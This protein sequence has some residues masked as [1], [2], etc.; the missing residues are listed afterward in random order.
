MMLLKPAK[1]ERSL[2]NQ[3]QLIRCKIPY[4]YLVNDETVETKSGHLLQVV[5]LEGLYA[6]TLDD[7]VL[8]QEKHAIQHLLNGLVDSSISLSFHMIRK[9]VSLTSA[10]K[11]DQPFAQSLHDKWQVVLDDK[12]FFTNHYYIAIVKK[13]PQ[14]KVRQVMDLVRQ[15]SVAFNKK[16]R[17][18][19]RKETLHALNKVTE[20]LVTHLNKYGA[21]QLGSVYDKK[22]NRPYSE[23]LSF[24]SY[25]INLEDRKILPPMADLANYL[26]YKRT[27]FD[28]TSG[29]IAFKNSHQQT[30]YA[31]M[32]SIKHYAGF[33]STIQLDP[34]LDAPCELVVTQTYS[35]LDKPQ[36]RQKVEEQA[37]NQAQSDD[38]VTRD[39]VKVDEAL[40]D[41]GSSEASMGEHTFSV[42]CHAANRSMLEEHI[43]K[44]DS[45]FSETGLIAL[46]E[47]AGINAAYFGSLPGNH[48]YH[49]RKA[50][51]ST[52][53]MASFTPFHNFYTGKWQGNRWGEPTTILE[54]ISGAPFAFNFHVGDVGNTFMVG[55]MG[56]GKTL[57]EGFLVA[58]SMKA[59]G[60]LFVFDKDRGME[61]L[62]RALGGTYSTLNAGQRT[63]MAPFQ[64]P[65][66]QAN[67]YALSTLMRLIA[68][69]NG[70]RLEDAELLQIK[71]MVNGVYQLPKNERIL[72]NV[73][74]FLGIKKK[75]SLRLR[76]ENWV[77]DGD[78]AW[79]FDNDVDSLSFNQ[80]I[81]GYDLTTILSDQITLKPIQY[82]LF[83]LLDNLLD[84]TPTRIVAAEAWQALED[85]AFRAKIK[86]W[87]STNRKKEVILILDT[88]AL[89][90]ISASPIGSKIIQESVTQIYFANPT[91]Q[92]DQYVKKFGLSEKEFEIIKALDK[93]SRFFLVKQGQ[94]SVVARAD[95][96]AMSDEIILLSN[97]HQFHP[98]FNAVLEEVDSDP[99]KWIPIYVQRIKH[100][101]KEGGL[102]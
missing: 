11:Y 66:T 48:A 99:D 10:A 75:G 31:A 13:P 91:G 27:F 56:S 36:A 95:L 45:L 57:L 39:M 34:L 38:S 60:R 82:Y 5:A 73:V 28:R 6:E 71:N 94:H 78:Y 30:R 22:M 51:L 85:E 96:S 18:E 86:D 61:P 54:T 7:F 15:L 102:K 37:R 90:D 76:F 49:V 21:R 33:S 63:G 77:N 70:Q 65:D 52:K 2:F 19:Y 42:L 101:I 100:A 50:M 62:V 74:S 55:P 72:R 26:P 8:D 67:R 23:L 59:G 14:G 53:H 9:A 92:Y 69:A 64:L 41:L 20:R 25:L 93:S 80:P 3:E 79:A 32:L 47:D 4:S 87:S 35:Y 58:L 44:L 98:V 81:M 29:T 1:K 43:A 83:H 46:R 97:R 16:A 68:E 88:Q 17:E 89:D 12:K 40:D 24:L 84:G